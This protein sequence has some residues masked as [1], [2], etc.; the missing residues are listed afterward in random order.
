MKEVT[1]SRT[2]KIWGLSKAEVDK[3]L[4][5]L[6]FT[7]PQISVYSK[8]DGI[9]VQLVAHAEEK[10]KSEKLLSAAAERCRSLFGKQIWG[11]DE[12]SLEALVGKLLQ[13]KGLTLATMESCTGG[14]LAD[15]ITNVPGSSDYFKGG[16]VTYSKEMKI[17]S[18]VDSQLIA[19]HGVV[20]S[21]VAEAMAEAVRQRVGTDVG[22]A[23]TGVAG[24]EP[25]EGKPVGTVYTGL[26]NGVRKKAVYCLYPRSRL[27]IKKSAAFGA[28]FELRKLLLEQAGQK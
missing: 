20:S 21:E 25:L 12:D 28:L 3:Q 14:L 26:S 10:E 22:V 4:G 6:L 23:T 1:L 5:S 16:L 27:E 9:H 24:P 11:Q 15:L 2:L 18:G 19:Q 8:F 7:N 17:A 13:K